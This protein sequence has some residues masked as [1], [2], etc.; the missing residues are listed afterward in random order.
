M[1]IR[2]SGLG[3]AGEYA[4]AMPRDGGLASRNG[5]DV[6]KA[7]GSVSLS[8]SSGAVSSGACDSSVEEGT[9]TGGGNGGVVDGKRSGADGASSEGGCGG[10]QDSGEGGGRTKEVGRSEAGTV[11]GFTSVSKDAST[12]LL[13]IR[14]GREPVASRF[15]DT[16]DLIDLKGDLLVSFPLDLE[17]VFRGER[18]DG[19]GAGAEARLA[20]KG[21]DA[22]GGSSTFV[23]CSSSLGYRINEH[24]YHTHKM[25]GNGHDLHATRMLSVSAQVCLVTGRDQMLKSGHSPPHQLEEGEK[26]CPPAPQRFWCFVL[27]SQL[28]ASSQPLLSLG[29]K[30]SN[31][32]VLLRLDARLT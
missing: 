1:R 13:A 21:A 7:G 2:L 27:D 18:R 12:R 16:D 5:F 32:Y 9:V 6:G 3:L 22:A 29:A 11:E 14:F 20:S 26:Q 30:M 25:S 28:R 10:R 31:F 17:R 8:S 4:C 23:L 15:V 19:P 24:R